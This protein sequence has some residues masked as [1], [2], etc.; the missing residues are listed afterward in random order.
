VAFREK[1]VQ[2]EEDAAL[3]NRFLH[4]EDGA[5]VGRVQPWERGSV[6]SL[7][8]DKLAG[9]WGLA[10]DALLQ[11]F[12]L[13]SKASYTSAEWIMAQVQPPCD[14]AQRHAG[15]LPYV[16]GLHIRGLSKSK[17]NDVKGKNNYWLSPPLRLDAEVSRLLFHLR[18]VTGLFRDNDLLKG[19][20]RLRLRDQLLGE[21]THE[22]H[23]YGGRPG[24]I[25]FPE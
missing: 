20:I 19:S 11:E 17:I 15:L 2:E 1:P 18:F 5:L 4:V 3:L 16:L 25:R 24:V 23:S 8:E 13:A 10:G 12:G 14:Q 7:P 22:L 9:L 21:L 6:V